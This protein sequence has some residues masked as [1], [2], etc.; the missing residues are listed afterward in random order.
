MTGICSISSQHTSGGTVCRV[1]PFANPTRFRI[2]LAA[3]GVDPAGAVVEVD[4][5]E[6]TVRFGP[7]RLRTPRSNITGTSVTGPYHAYRAIG[8]RFSL[9][10]RGITFGSTTDSGLCIEFAE[11]VPVRFLDLQLPLR[12]PNVTVTVADPEALRR[13]LT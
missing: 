2:P 12:H 13:S 7:W 9:S 10:D 11:P 4:E 5:A 1:H 6:L 3:L 8:V